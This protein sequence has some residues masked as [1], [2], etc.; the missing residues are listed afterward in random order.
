V[1]VILVII[2]STA[3]PLTQMKR[4]DVAHGGPTDARVLCWF[5][6]DYNAEKVDKTLSYINAKIM[7]KKDVYH[8]DHTFSQAYKLFGR[9]EI[10][11][12]PDRDTQ[13]YQAVYRKVVSGLGLSDYRRLSREELTED[14]KKNLPVIPGVR[15]RTTWREEEGTETSLSYL[16]RGYDIGV[17]ENLANELENRL[18]LEEGVFS[19]ETDTETGNATVVDTTPSSDRMQ[20]QFEFKRAEC[21]AFRV[22]LEDTD[23]VGNNEGM[24]ITS[25]VI[26]SQPQPTPVQLAPS[27]TIGLE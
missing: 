21:Q 25:M 2:L 13:W 12:E 17:L 15:L 20:I 7:E 18:K 16:L 26:E 11:L 22:T 27:D 6:P 1:I 19:V 3:W 9:I 24:S 10:Y 8:I 5:P 4:S 14:I 23:T